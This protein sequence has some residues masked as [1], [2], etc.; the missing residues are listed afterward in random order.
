MF[1]AAAADALATRNQSPVTR[2]VRR[3][4]IASM[5]G[6]AVMPAIADIARNAVMTHG[7]SA[8]SPR[9]SAIAGSAATSASPSNAA[10]ATIVRFASVTGRYDGDQMPPP[11]SRC[12]LRC[13]TGTLPTWFARRPTLHLPVVGG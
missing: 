8:T 9:S 13:H 7:R 6:P 5:I 2:N 4:P 10:I 3:T 1:G 11:G 12:H